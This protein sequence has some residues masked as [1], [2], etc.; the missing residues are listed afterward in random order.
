ML[1]KLWGG[2]FVGN[3]RIQLCLVNPNP[4]AS[5]F[6]TGF[7]LIQQTAAGAANVVATLGSAVRQACGGGAAEED[8]V[9][10]EE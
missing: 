10:A 7:E 9:S 6:L 1:L 3:S 4:I 2:T 8:D 5:L